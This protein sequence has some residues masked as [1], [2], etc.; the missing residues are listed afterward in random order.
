MLLEVTYE[1]GLVGIALLLMALAL[2]LVA[3]MRAAQQRVAFNQRALLAGLTASYIAAVINA[4][5][6]GDLG[7]N[8]LIG[9]FGAA[10]V[11]TV[12]AIDRQPRRAA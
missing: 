7:A 9:M 11:S 3:V 10:T 5:F 12:Q 6:T 4:Q 1:N 2:P 8:L